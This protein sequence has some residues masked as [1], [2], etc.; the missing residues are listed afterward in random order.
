MQANKGTAN[1]MDDTV[2]RYACQAQKCKIIR[3]LDEA[4][5]AFAAL[6]PDEAYALDF[7]TTDL[8]PEHG[9]VRITTI[10]GYNAAFMIDHWF[11]AFQDIVQELANRT[12]WVF[13]SLFEGN[14]IDYYAENDHVTLWDVQ[15]LKKAKMGGGPTSLAIMAK[16]DLGYTMN[17]TEQKGDWGQK[18]LTSEQ[19]TYAAIDGFVTYDLALH[20]L[21][22][23]DDK[24]WNGFLVI[25]DAW[26]GTLEME[27]N[28][29]HVDVEYHQKIVKL[30]QTKHDTAE[31]YLRKWTPPNIIANLRSRKQL[32]DFLKAQLDDKSIAVWPK[33][34]KSGEKAPEKQQLSTESNVIRHAAHRTQYPF[35]RWLAA[36]LIFNYYE[37][38]LGTYGDKLIWHMQVRGHIPTRFNMAQAITGRYSSSAENLQNIPRSAVVRRSFTPL[39]LNRG[40]SYDD[41]VRVIKRYKETGEVLQDIVVLVMADYSSIEVRV[42]AEVSGD[43]Q[44]RQ[45]A[46][47]GDVHS[48]SA[49]QIF[50]IDYDYFKEVIDSDGKGRYANVYPDFKNKRSRA[51]AF[52]FQLLYGAGAS[53]LA[54]VL[55][56]DD[57]DANAAIMAWASLYPTAYHYRQYMFEVM[58]NTGFLPVQD[59]RTIFVWKN[60]RTMPVAANYPI[61]GAAASV[62]YRAIY[63]TSNWLRS[64]DKPIEL[65]ATVHDELLLYSRL[66]CADYAKQQL[67]RRMIRGWSD[68]FPNTDT[69]KLVDAK[70]GASWG[71]K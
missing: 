31:R 41:M 42:L 35:K 29:L 19:W 7:E 12:W 4:L 51:K 23:T 21:E 55:N 57:D 59:G 36:L 60:D 22:E 56:C 52:T 10:V 39:P 14:W 63:H 47:Y 48:R 37:K 6:D 53:A 44:L 1:A 9:S 45:D 30:W 18:E 49:S 15:H 46:I 61:Q 71:D 25:N 32:S 13:N 16:Q 67:E 64:A 34:G 26:R 27:L 38:Y 2:D 70:I 65:C 68:I 11:V 5:A 62:M 20:W 66:S 54:I 50:N 3:K 24:I 69:T 58:H 17:K 28:A 40:V 43:A 33:T 8:L